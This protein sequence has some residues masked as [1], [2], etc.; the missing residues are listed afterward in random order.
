MDRNDSWFVAVKAVLRLWPLKCEDK[1]CYDRHDLWLYELKIQSHQLVTKNLN[2]KFEGHGCR[3]CQVITWTTFYHSM[4]TVT[5]TFGLMTPQNIRGHVL[6]RCPISKSSLKGHGFR[7][8]Q[9]ITQKTSNHSRWLWPWPL[10]LWILI[11]IRVIY[12][13][14]LTSMSSLMIIGS[15]IVEISVGEDLL[16]FL[17]QRLLWHWPW[18]DDPQSR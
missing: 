9:V 8:C 16:T 6:V 13:S 4:F 14:G 18:P 12:W 2:V 5:L 3:H 7:H 1:V 10:A 17:R 11:S 15:G